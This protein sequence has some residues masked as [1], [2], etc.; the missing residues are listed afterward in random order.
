MRFA[1]I[2]LALSLLFTTFASAQLVDT[3]F[4]D[5]TPLSDVDL[6]VVRERAYGAGGIDLTQYGS[7]GT[8]TYV[9]SL[10]FRLRHGITFNPRWISGR[11]ILPPGVNVLAVVTDGND[12]GG[13]T[14]DGVASD[15]DLDFGLT[16][17]A[18]VY[19]APLRGLAWAEAEAVCVRSN[20][21]VDFYLFARQ[22]DV[23]DFR[24][25]ID[26]GSSFPA[27]MSFDIEL[28]TVSGVEDLEHQ[29]GIRIGDPGGA[30]FGN[31]DYGEVPGLD[32]IPLTA[33]AA[34]TP[35][36]GH[37]FDPTTGILFNRTG[38]AH[39]GNHLE[40]WD[41][42]AQTF[43]KHAWRGLRSPIRNGPY[44]Y[45]YGPVLNLSGFGVIDPRNGS[46]GQ[47]PVSGLLGAATGLDGDPGGKEVVIAGHQSGLNSD[48][49]VNV[50]N[51]DTATTVRTFTYPV[52]QIT[53]VEGVAWDG[54]S[55]IYL[56]S[57]ANEF[58][59][60]DALTGAETEF[61]GPAGG[62]FRD[63]VMNAAG[64]EV[65]TL[66]QAGVT[67]ASQIGV[68][69]V[70]GGTY[71]PV[72]VVGS[73]STH[74]RSATIDS[75][76]IL[77]VQRSGFNDLI[78]TGFSQFDMN[79]QTYLGITDCSISKSSNGILTDVSPAMLGTQ[80]CDPAELNS[81]GWPGRIAA[82]GS[83]SV[84]DNEFY[85]FG[86]DLPTSQ[87]A[88]VLSAPALG[89]IANP[90]GSNGNLCLGIN[91]GRHNSQIEFTSTN[92]SIRVPVDLTQ[93]P[94][95]MGPFAITAGTT[96]FFQIWHRESN[97]Q[98]NFTDVVEVTFQ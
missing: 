19:S 92:R 23:D 77:T 2:L 67:T 68:Y 16:G 72:V 10:Y 34:P 66:H 4:D 86:Y 8:H 98:S 87:F 81:Q 49:H 42:S 58:V 31:G 40:W 85:I 90:G 96:R 54:G 57:Q 91:I 18:D 13:S 71:T 6:V 97:G 55:K 63:V 5:T 50:V 53:G 14:D 44:G 36:A 80:H 48:L 70:L 52:G 30:V 17:M 82:M 61:A 43:I 29:A 41:P 9:Q 35:N 26:Y 94:S 28:H 32:D 73:D 93:M 62:T 95:A 69:D 27:D 78:M 47:V 46:F 75:A 76:G 11:I 15:S 88:Y 64:T 37:E 51:V 21:A 56:V 79:T 45:I 84:T 74:P 38:G 39:S 12:L 83:L 7:L 24:L 22:D 59:V 65:Y 1:L 33:L 20:N 89:F 3:G 25:I 60:I